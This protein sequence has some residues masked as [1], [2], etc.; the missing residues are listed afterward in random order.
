M[1]MK[2]ICWCSPSCTTRTAGSLVIYEPWNDQLI[3]ES[4]LWHF[5]TQ[6]QNIGLCVDVTRLR[7]RCRPFMVVASIAATSFLGLIVGCII[8]PVPSILLVHQVMNYLQQFQIY[9]LCNPCHW[10][11][12]ILALNRELLQLLP[13]SVPF[14]LKV[15]WWWCPSSQKSL[16]GTFGRFSQQYQL[17][18]VPTV[19]M[20]LE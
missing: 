1:W 20:C 4:N 17:Q 2:E 15:L 10:W 12:D 6:L 3:L 8:H 7:I 9:Y 16:R 19:N 13:L 5:S 11:K 18:F 14:L